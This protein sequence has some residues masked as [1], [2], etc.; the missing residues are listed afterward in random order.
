M[1]GTLDRGK[2]LRREPPCAKLSLLNAFAPEGA[3]SLVEHVVARDQGGRRVRS[4]RRLVVEGLHGRRLDA[5]R[6]VEV[7]LDVGVL[8]LRS[9]RAARHVRHVGTQRVH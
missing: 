7:L 1:V 9:R 5:G 2:K 8:P 6:V 4:D 3:V